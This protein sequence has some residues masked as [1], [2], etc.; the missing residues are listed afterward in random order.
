MTNVLLLGS[1]GRENALAIAL[2]K[3]PLLKTLLVVPGK[4]DTAEI[5]EKYHT[6][7]VA[8]VVEWLSLLF[9]FLVVAARWPT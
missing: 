9:L 8:N 7:E 6:P 4:P 2:A 1:G 3:S 5:G